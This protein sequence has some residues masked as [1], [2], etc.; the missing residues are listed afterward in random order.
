MK[1]VIVM[2]VSIL[3]IGCSPDPATER[4]MDGMRAVSKEECEDRVGNM[5]WDGKLDKNEY[6]HA[7]AMCWATH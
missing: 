1:L 3:L 5:F 4:I 6:D 7:M 2:I